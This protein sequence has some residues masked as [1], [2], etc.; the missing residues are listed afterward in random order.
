MD[1]REE[2]NKFNETV[3]MIVR[4]VPSGVVTTYGQVAAMIP[5]PG[6][7]ALPHY[8]RIRAQWVG[9]AMRNS[10]EGVPWQRVVNSQGG[11][12]LPAGSRSAAI[13]RMRLEAEGIEFDRNG[14]VNLA[15]FGWSGPDLSW[16]KE[17]GLQP[18]PSLREEIPE[19][20]GLFDN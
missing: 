8:Q 7:M 14:R 18:A 16:L 19:Q 5:P 20:L 10:P 9:R 1:Q 15:R 3:Y 13:Q 12:S 6:N 2:R 11:I 17:H 4:R